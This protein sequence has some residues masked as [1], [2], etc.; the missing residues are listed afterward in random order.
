MITLILL[1]VAVVAAAYLVLW[2]AHKRRADNDHPTG[3]MN[4]GHAI[5]AYREIPPARAPVLEIC[6]ERHRHEIGGGTRVTVD[7]HF[8]EVKK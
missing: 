1:P 5:I 8:V 7:S 2:L 6:L 4:G 3:P